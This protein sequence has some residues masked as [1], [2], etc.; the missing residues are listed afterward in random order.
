[1]ATSRKVVCSS[2]GATNMGVQESCMICGVRLPDVQQASAYT[3]TPQPPGAVATPAAPAAV[4]APA[5]RLCS[6]CGARLP[7]TGR[8][9]I[10]CGTPADVAAAPA[11]AP[12]C[13]NCGAALP[14]GGRFCVNCGTP[15]TA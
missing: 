13:R 3:I 9:C 6:H 12:A 10:E 11:A 5:E 14:P 2:C 15:V 7:E 8:F 4:S 1:M